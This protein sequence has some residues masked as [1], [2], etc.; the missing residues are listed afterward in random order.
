MQVS[1][2]KPEFYVLNGNHITILDDSRV[3]AAINGEVIENIEDSKAGIGEDGSVDKL[4][5]GAEIN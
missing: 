4:L 1:N 3:A 5:A 2:K